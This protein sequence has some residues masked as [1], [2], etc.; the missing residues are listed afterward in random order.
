MFSYCSLKSFT[1]N[2]N[3]KINKNKLIDI[4]GEIKQAVLLLYYLLGTVEIFNPF[5]YNTL[6]ILNIHQVT[7]IFFFVFWLSQYVKL[8]INI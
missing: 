3:G 2:E 4:D 7:M 6:F 1:N 8:E 5:I